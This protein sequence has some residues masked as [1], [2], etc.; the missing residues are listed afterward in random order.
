VAER[1][2]IDF[3]TLSWLEAG[4]SQLALEHFPGFATALG[5]RSTS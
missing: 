1:A 4:K 2:N 5:V 3:S